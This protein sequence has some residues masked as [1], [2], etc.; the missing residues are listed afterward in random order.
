M[1]SQTCLSD[2]QGAGAQFTDQAAKTACVKDW[3]ISL[4]YIQPG[5]PQQNAYVER[6]NRT[7]RHEWLTQY[8]WSDLAEVQD[9]ATKWMWPYNHDRPNTAV[10]GFTPKQPLAMAVQ[11]FY[12]REPCKRV[13]LPYR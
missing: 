3:G 12:F 8:Y 10:G 13:G 2:L 1:E 4:E 11:R 6:F 7:V 9:F 5:N